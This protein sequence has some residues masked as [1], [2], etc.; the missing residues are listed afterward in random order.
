MCNQKLELPKCGYHAMEYTFLETGEPE[1]INKPDSTLVLQDQNRQPLQIEQ[2]SNDNAA[3]YLGGKKSPSS[4]TPQFIALKAKCD[5]HGRVINCSHLNRSEALTFYFKIYRLSA[6]YAL[7]TRYFTELELKKAQ[8]KSHKAFVTKMGYNRNMG[9]WV[10]YRPQYLGGEALFHL[11]GDQG[12]GQVKLFIKFWRSPD[13]K[14]GVLLRI[15]IC[16]AQYSVG[17]SFFPPFRHRD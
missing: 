1:L 12:Y 15:A 4:K 3:Q 11:Y 14:P 16:R 5:D 13:S 8:M 9:H 10:L 2:W 17:T 6:R 7:P